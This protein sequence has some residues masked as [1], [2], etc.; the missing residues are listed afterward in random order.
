MVNVPVWIHG[1]THIQKTYR[2][3]DT[4]L[5]ANCRG[6]EGKDASA[7]SFTPRTHFDL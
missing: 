3:G 5:H 4:T 1:H 2:V 6:F 7:R